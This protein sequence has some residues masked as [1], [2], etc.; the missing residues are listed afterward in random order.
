MVMMIDVYCRC[1][2]LQGCTRKLFLFTLKSVLTSIMIIL[3]FIFE[4]CVGQVYKF[5]LTSFFLFDLLE[6]L[7]HLNGCI[8]Q[9][10]AL[11][12]TKLSVNERSE[13]S[14]KSFHSWL[15]EFCQQLFLHSPSCHTHTQNAVCRMLDMLLTSSKSHI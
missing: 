10:T 12:G 1:G 7:C 11:P 14:K 8:K 15:R 6:N 13:A 3:V 5:S 9:T 2:I 4:M